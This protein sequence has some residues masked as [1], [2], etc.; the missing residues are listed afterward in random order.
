MDCCD[1]RFPD[2]VQELDGN[3]EEVPIGSHMPDEF[4]ATQEVER[5]IA[6]EFRVAKNACHVGETEN[7]PFWA[8]GSNVADAFER[9]AHQP[10]A[11]REAT[12]KGE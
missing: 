2:L 3:V 8:P 6:E 12:G 1:P 5:A 10:L 11:T 9:D 4:N 7:E